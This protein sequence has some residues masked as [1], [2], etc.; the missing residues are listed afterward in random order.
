LK[1]KVLAIAEEAGA[2]RATYALKLLQSEGELSI[3]STGKDPQSGRLVTHEYRVEG[4]V[5]IVLTTTRAEIDEELLNRCLVLTVDEE[6][7]Q[8]QAIHRLQRKRETLE[9]QLALRERPEIEK[10]HRNAQR[11]LRPLLVANPFAEHLTFP[12]SA[13]RMRRDHEKYLA[14][15][16]AAALLHQHQREVKTTVRSGQAVEYVEATLEDIAIAN[17]L[18]RE[19]LGRTLDE[20]PPQTR[21]LL[22]LL[23]RHVQAQCARLEIART[24]YRFTRREARAVTSWGDTQLRLHLFRLESLEYLVA[25]RGR[26]GQGYVYELAYEVQK[27]E[28]TAS[29]AGL[30]DVES[31]GYDGKNAGFG[32]HLA[33]LPT[34]YAGGKR[35]FRGGMAGGSR[36]DSERARTG[37][38]GDFGAESLETAHWGAAVDGSASYVPARRTPTDEPSEA[39]LLSL[40][41]FAGS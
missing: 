27:G 31:L 22:V 16:R 10:L 29:L 2:E 19:V 37:F 35:P 36:G 9:G 38:P 40:A 17:R 15:I 7:E 11:L 12:D 41:S 20:L 21:K 25:H 8:T 14:L 3:A 5:A 24:E 28:E 34:D 39:D 30:I 6:R 13:A 18:A 33:G 23:D 32:A 26:R 4:P 1:H